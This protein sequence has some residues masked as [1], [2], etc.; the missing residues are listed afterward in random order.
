MAG[1]ATVELKSRELGLDLAGRPDVLAT[2]TDRIKQLEA[3]GWSFEAADASFE[4]LVRG[5]L[6]DGPARPFSLESYRVIVEHREDGAVVSEATVKVRVRGERVVATGEATGPVN[7]L[8]AALRAALVRHFPVLSTVDLHDYKVRILEGSH[9]TGAVTRVLVESGTEDREWTTVG[10][11]ENVIEA[12]WHA[13]VDA[14]TYG[15]GALAPHAA[16]AHR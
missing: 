8:D 13:L 3:A 4:L 10:V 9:G 6:G 7:A 12:S 11:H 15:V 1:R 2:V 5:E 16:T 14:L